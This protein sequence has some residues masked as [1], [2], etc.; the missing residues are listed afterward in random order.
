VNANNMQ[1]AAG[2]R[3]WAAEAAAMAAAAAGAGDGKQRRI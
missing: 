3:Q 2:S 1:H